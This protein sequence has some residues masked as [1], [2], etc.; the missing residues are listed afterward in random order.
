M[1]R[2]VTTRALLVAA[3]GCA[4][5]VSG[6][7]VGAVAS[8]G[9][10]SRGGP[11]PSQWRLAVLALPTP[12][13][14]CYSATYPVLRWN[15]VSCFLPIVAAGGPGQDLSPPHAVRPAQVGHG[16]DYEALAGSGSLIS[17]ATGSFKNVSSPITVTSETPHHQMT[18]ISGAFMLQLNSNGFTTPAC[19]TK[20]G[21]FGWQQFFYD[22]QQDGVYMQ[23]WLM[24]YGTPCPTGWYPQDGDC[25]TNSPGAYSQNVHNGRVTVSDLQTTLFTASAVAGGSDT[26]SIASGVIAGRNVARDNKLGLA[27]GWTATEFGAFGDF[28]GRQAHFGANTHLTAVT[29]L[30][31]SGT[32]TAPTCVVAS[33]F[34][35]FT[36]ETNNLTLSQTSALTV[37]P[38]AEI[39]STQTNHLPKPP[40]CATAK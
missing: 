34:P 18:Q 1:V 38:R 37:G 40:S 19:G 31:A 15:R 21:C 7:A 13:Q 5:A 17:S 35:V 12:K 20:A 24:N 10:S 16:L 9:I 25:F 27:S 32:L 22:E 33:T 2:L 26:V 28:G 6:S 14:G 4:V 23:Y 29:T 36:K 39:A 3:V 8:H 11:N 30:L